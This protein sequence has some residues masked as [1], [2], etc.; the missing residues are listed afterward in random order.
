MSRKCLIPVINNTCQGVAD[1]YHDFL[2][3]HGF[4]IHIVA[5]LMHTFLMRITT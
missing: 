4:L 1:A 2:M 5:F 3:H